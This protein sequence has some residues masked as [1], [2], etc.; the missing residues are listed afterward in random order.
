[1]NKDIAE[2]EE[3]ISEIDAELS[4]PENGYNP[5]LLNELTKERTE[6]SNKLDELMSDW[7]E[8]SNILSDY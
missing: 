5:G 6:L 3:R 7:E 8:Y 1:M 2:A 4:K